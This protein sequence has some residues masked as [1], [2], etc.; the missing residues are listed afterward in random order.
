MQQKFFC[1]R[2]NKNKTI[3]V[4]KTCSQGKV[5][6]A[7]QAVRSQKLTLNHLCAVFAR[8]SYLPSSQFFP[9]KVSI[10]VFYF[11]SFTHLLIDSFT[12]RLW[13]A[14]HVSLSVLGTGDMAVNQ[15]DKALLS[16]VGRD[17]KQVTA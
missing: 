17:N 12:T 9:K 8:P 1:K 6:C 16:K 14:C 5:R 10:G 7:P 3:C 13:N 4:Q 2:K 15:A 11:V